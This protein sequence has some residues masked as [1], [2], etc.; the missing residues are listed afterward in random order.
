[1]PVAFQQFFELLITP[2]GNLVYHLVL[3]FSISSALPVGLFLWKTTLFPHTR[4]TVMGLGALLI[5]QIGLFIAGG[6]VWQGIISEHNWLP[7]LERVISLLSLVILIWLW[8]FP[9][10]QRKGDLACRLIFIIL[11]MV[12]IFLCSWWAGQK[13]QAAFNSSL[14]DRLVTSIEIFAILSALVYLIWKRPQQWTNAILFFSILFSGYLIQ[15]FYPAA[16]LDYSP[17][18]RFVELV[19]YPLLILLPLHFPVEVSLDE[20]KTTPSAQPAENTIYPNELL[21]IEKSLDLPLDFQ[22][23]KLGKNLSQLIALALRADLCLLVSPPDENWQ[24]TVH[25][26][27]DLIREKNLEGDNWDGKAFPTLS[28]ALRHGKTLRLYTETAAPDLNNLSSLLHINQVGNLLTASIVNEENQP[29]YG[30]LLISP[31]SNRHW[32]SEEQD[33]LVQL[34]K[35]FSKLISL[36]KKQSETNTQLAE[37]EQSLIQA[38]DNLSALQ[39]ELQ[40]RAQTPTDNFPSPAENKHSSEQ[41]SQEDELHLALEEI[42]RLDN[43]IRKYQDSLNALQSRASTPEGNNLFSNLAM[44]LRQPLASI[45]GYTDFLLGESV[46]ILG[47]LQRKFLE[48]IRAATQR[49]NTILEDYLSEVSLTSR[50]MS[51]NLT[52]IDILQHLHDIVAE[53]EMGRQAKRQQIQLIIP[54]EIPPMQADVETF[55]QILRLLVE[56]AQQVTPEQGQIIVKVELKQETEKSCY[57][58]IQIQDQGSGISADDLPQVFSPTRRD[59][60]P[61]LGE[62]GAALNILKTLV[63]TLNGRIWVD[64]SPGNGTTFSILFP[65]LQ[66]VPETVES[67]EDP[68]EITQ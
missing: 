26:G 29:V 15:L 3:A 68:N 4:R 55:E 38:Q 56:N 24:I 53:T 35:S 8:A 54:T 46:G 48:R 59:I 6:L 63:E 31:Y 23:G 45:L 47:A 2:T 11:L 22:I 37:T 44:E 51:S 40:I 33:H 50:R 61:G 57:L 30:I 65:F 39:Q 9:Q 14:M 13:S 20:Q 67:E 42:A 27:Y 43:E 66:N 32:S 36:L 52:A 16:D 18:I 34:T 1:M 60:P 17:Y 62:S 28:A 7:V 12:S 49:I 21:L 64:S 5:L 19:A 10:P 58:L 25:G 41:S